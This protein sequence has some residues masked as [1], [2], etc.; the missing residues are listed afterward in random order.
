[1]KQESSKVIKKRKDINKET[2]DQNKKRI[3]KLAV[4]VLI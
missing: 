1:M 4:K 2:K 3:E